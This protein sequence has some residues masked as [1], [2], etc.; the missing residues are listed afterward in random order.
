MKVYIDI[1]FFTNF[2][3]D[4]ILLFSVSLILKRNTK[5]SKII[6]GSFFGTLTLLILFIRMNFI[7]LFLYKFLI[8]ILMVLITYGYKNIKYTFKNL[9]YLYIVSIIMGGFLYFINNQV[10]SKNEGLLFINNNFSI[11]LVLAIILTIFFMMSYIKSSKN[12]KENYNKYY[13]VTII[14]SNKEKIKVN[15][16]LDTGNKLIDPY[17][18]RP[19]IL[20]KE[21]IINNTNNMKFIP[22]PFSTVSGTGI[23]KCVIPYKIYINEKEI[24][25]KSLIGITN[26]INIDGVSCILNEKIMEG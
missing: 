6:L 1:V 3:F 2:L 11:N 18:R 20:L 13:N 17:K 15:A 9:Y 5:L 7:T 12:L 19:V 24:K 4:F 26:N 25:K 23:L 8:S 10:S 14:L 16:F 21:N 22:V